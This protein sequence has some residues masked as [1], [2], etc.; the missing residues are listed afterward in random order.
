MVDRLALNESFPGISAFSHT[1][2]ANGLYVFDLST[3]PGAP[4]DQEGGNVVY[5][6]S[7]SSETIT[8]FKAGNSEILPRQFQLGYNTLTANVTRIPQV[9]HSASSHAT[10]SERKDACPK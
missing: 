4:E 9:N 10:P 8:P 1:W 3:I 2:V 7:I 5:S 6:T